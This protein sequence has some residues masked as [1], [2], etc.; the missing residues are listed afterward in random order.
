MISENTPYNAVA[1]TINYTR[2]NMFTDLT[3]THFDCTTY[4][5][6]SLHYIYKYLNNYNWNTQCLLAESTIFQV[7]LVIYNNTGQII[8]INHNTGYVRS[9]W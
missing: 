7:T 6:G 8:S 9:E 4:P 3:T 1:M 2:F 5:S